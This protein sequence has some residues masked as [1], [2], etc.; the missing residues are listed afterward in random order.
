LKSI[1]ET[2]KSKLLLPDQ[3]N[4]T[5]PLGTGATET[6]RPD[7]LALKLKKNGQ[8]WM[9]KKYLK[10]QIKLHWWLRD[11]ICY[12]NVPDVSVAI[13]DLLQGK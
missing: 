4:Q 10:I 5:T 13:T 1:L 11:N 12:K 8:E 6:E 2:I 7:E 3:G 9:F